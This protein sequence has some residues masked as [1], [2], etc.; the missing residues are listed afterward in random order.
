MLAVWTILIAGSLL[1]WAWICHV[2]LRNPRQ[3]LETGL[4]WHAMRVYSTLFH[5][6]EIR[7]GEH[8]PKTRTPG[9]LIIV[10]NHT[11]GVDPVLI[12]A[13]SL[14]EIRWL[15]AQDMRH[16]A[17]EWAWRF[18]RI[19]FVDRTGDA[20]GAREAIRHV[21]GGGVLGIFPEGGI[22]R[23]ARHILPF[24]A[25]VGMIIK[26]TQAPVLPV[27]V[28]GTPIADRA[29]TSL[30][31]RSHSV[32]TFHPVLHYPAGES[33]AA[34]AKDLEARFVELTGWPSARGRGVHAEAS[35][36]TSV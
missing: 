29:W 17:L 27:V 11:A 28:T 12:Q 22:E 3:D 31:R 18:G 19:I 9:S 16:P 30:M 13:A 32:I 26:R 8:L 1:V 6:L 21:K 36:A 2:L 25:G 23:P 4:I 20:M 33:A 15:M 14:F 5:R 7:G 35:A 10:S 24:Q 34:I